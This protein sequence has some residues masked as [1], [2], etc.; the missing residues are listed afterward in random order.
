MD[1]R[2]LRRPVADLFAARPQCILS[3]NATTRR[4]ESSFRRTKQRLNIRPDPNFV[5]TKGALQDHIVFNPPSSSPSVFHTP[6][7]FL[8]KDDKRRKILSITQER[9]NALS[10]HRLPPLVN[11]KQFRYE[12]GHLSEK[13]VAEI[14]RLRA[15]QPER[16]TRLQLSKKFQCSSIFIGMITEA[17]EEKRE[18]ERQKLEAVK[19]KW[20]PTRTAARENRQRRVELAKRDG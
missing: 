4:Y 19:A 2:I 10:K 8:P 18:L 6:L 5:P 13:D 15:D 3:L 9:I 14:R 16:W 12:R 7:K 17:P 11:P 1:L 20:G